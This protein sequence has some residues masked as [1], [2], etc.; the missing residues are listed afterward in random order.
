MNNEARFLFRVV[1]LVG[2]PRVICVKETFVRVFIGRHTG[3][4]TR[5]NDRCAEARRMGRRGATDQG[6]DGSYMS[7]DVLRSEGK[8]SR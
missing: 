8:L 3:S 7:H 4:A 1:R 6:E 2:R 5:N